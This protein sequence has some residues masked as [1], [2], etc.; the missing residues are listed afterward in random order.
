MLPCR[1]V[2]RLKPSP[3]RERICSLFTLTNA[4]IVGSAS[5]NVRPDSPSAVALGVDRRLEFQRHP[6]HAVAQA[7]G[8]RAVVEHVAE[9]AEAPPAMQ[10]GEGC[11]EATVCL[12]LDRIGQRIKEARPAR[13]AFELGIGG[14]QRQIATCASEDALAVLTVER[15]G[16]RTFGAVI[17]QDVVLRRRQALAPV[18]VLQFLPVGVLRHRPRNQGTA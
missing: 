9:M 15:A 18:R 4:S 6:V 7:G 8:R 1:I 10:L 3:T 13:A 14:K 17:A 16:A 5:R 12:G 2:V 11:K